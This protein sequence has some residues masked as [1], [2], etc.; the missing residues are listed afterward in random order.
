MD[1]VFLNAV[2][3][4]VMPNAEM[5]GSSLYNF[6]RNWFS[7]DVRLEDDSRSASL[8]NFCFSNLAAT[9][10]PEDLLLEARESLRLEV[11]L[12]AVYSYD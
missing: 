1:M 7:R 10:S 9:L 11:D 12:W 3:L 5:K 2:S 6:L 4:V 8:P